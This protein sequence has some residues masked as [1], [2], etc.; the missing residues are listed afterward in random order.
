MLYLLSGSL[1]PAR[2]ITTF[3]IQRHGPDEIYRVFAPGDIML[4]GSAA[5][6]LREKGYSHPFRDRDLSCITATADASF[7][8]LE[9]PVTLHDIRCRDKAFVFRGD[10]ET[11]RAI[12]DAGFNMLSLANNHIMDCNDE[13]LKDT[14][15]LCDR[16]GIAHAGAGIDLENAGRMALILR[17]GMRF[18]LLAY[19]MTYPLEFWAG[20][21][22]AGT[23][24]PEYS[25]IEKDIAKAKSQVD[26]LLVSFHWGEELKSEPKSYQTGLARSAV[27]SGADMVLG[28]HPH[29]AQAIE[30]YRGKP[31]F[32]SLGNY[33]F[34]SYSTKVT[35][36]FAAEIML[37]GR[38]IVQ[39]NLHPLNLRSPRAVFQ[40]A[41]A[42]GDAA[43]LVI[44]RLQDLSKPFGTSIM[45]D[46]AKGIIMISN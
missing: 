25:R 31:I 4:A 9:Y 22:R 21:G 37:R 20:P 12:R 10:P 5:S 24:H 27:R 32:Y 6:V 38:K 11:L 30:I 23:Y 15:R 45:L 14:I 41:V 29:V 33:A 1:S 35:T 8:N 43:R 2:G 16:L 26:I 28:H 42:G 34:G 46:G 17:R 7:A 40:P 13:G 36:G 3:F 39:V 44:T 18:G 19:S